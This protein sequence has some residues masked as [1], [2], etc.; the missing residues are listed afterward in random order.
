[1]HEHFIYPCEIKNGNYMPPKDFGY[2]IEMKQKSIE[3]YK[4]PNG[5][6]WRKNI[7]D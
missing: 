6:Y 7:W 3:K 1:L 2:S 5:E 4:F